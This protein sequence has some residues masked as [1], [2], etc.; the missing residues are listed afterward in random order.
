MAVELHAAHKGGLGRDL[1]HTRGGL[2]P[3]AE[4]SLDLLLGEHPVPVGVGGLL[5]LVEVPHGDA[6]LEVAPPWG[7]RGRVRRGGAG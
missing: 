5:E 2:A 3:L 7:A 4:A 6:G 1:Q